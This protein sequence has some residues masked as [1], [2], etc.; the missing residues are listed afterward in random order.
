MSRRLPPW[1]KRKKT[2]PELPLEPPIRLGNMSNGEFFHQSTPQEQRIRAEILR[3]AEEKA[4]KLNMDRREFLSSAMGM[5]TSLSVLNMAAACSSGT[6]ERNNGFFDIGGSSGSGNGG[7]PPGM[8][9]SMAP[10]S[11]SG[12]MPGIMVGP[13]GQPAIAMGGSPG[14]MGGMPGQGS[15]GMVSSGGGGMGGYP[16]GGGAG[17]YQIPPNAT[18]DCAMAEDLLNGKGEFIMDCQT[19]HIEQEGDWRTTNPGQADVLA[20]Y[21]AQY[22]MCSKSD[23]TMCIDAQSYLEQIFLNS[24]TTLAVLSGYPAPLCTE[25]RTTG[26]GNPLDNDAMWKSREQFN[27]IGR[28][29]RVINHCQVN[30]TD[31]LPAQLALME[32]IKKEH[33][34]W[35]FKSYPEWGPDG[36]GWMLDDPNSGIKMIEKARELD[37]KIICVHKGIVFPGWDRAASTP[38]DVGVVAKMYPDVAFVVYHSAIEIDGSGEGPY[39]P[40]NTMGT[41]RLCRA[42]VDNQLMGKNMYAELGS[43]WAQVM[44]APDK[45]QHVIGKLVKYLG[46]D[47]VVW[48]SECVW[49]G[50]PQ[51]QIEAFRTF[52]IS[53]EYQDKYG[54]PELTPEIKAKIFGLNAARI[55]KINP[56]ECR[57]KIKQTTLAQMKLNLDGEFGTRRWAFKLPGGPR[58]RREFWNLARLTGGKP[59]V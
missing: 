40:D 36:T 50:S 41:D 5:A 23:L 48:G 15:G 21:F 57:Y 8:G 11:A 3:Q 18:M 55:Y 2:A 27:M 53:K 12:G 6:G 30:P 7:L 22:N 44:N 33:G 4:R 52:Q 58:T 47:N 16:G 1:L 49:L 29:Q 51:A 54:Y 45:A 19:H 26:C 13:G 42:A 43:C 37:S 31:N 46:P 38:K 10:A 20:A 24:D 17:G 34:C 14:A 32:R 59:G 25:T 9:G 35:G 39:N 56:D 28:S